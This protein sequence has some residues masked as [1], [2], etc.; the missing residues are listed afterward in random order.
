[1]KTAKSTERVNKRAVVS[2]AQA[3]KSITQ[4]AM[5][6]KGVTPGKKLRVGRAVNAF[7]TVKGGD[8][9]SAT[10]IVQLR[11][12][13]HL[14]NNPM[15]AHRIEPRAKSRRGRGRKKALTI[16]Q[17]VRASANHPGTKG[18]KFWE[19]SEA[20]MRRRLPDVMRKAHIENWIKELGG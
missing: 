17:N 20:E 7:Y 1:M 13:A 9:G 19:A 14:V 12:P 11:G 4:S 18:K 2:A 5:S 6:S 10:A 3:G 16:G 15:Q 8:G